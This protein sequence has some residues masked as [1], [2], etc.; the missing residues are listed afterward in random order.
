MALA[1]NLP[2][3][4]HLQNGKYTLGRVLGEGGFGITYLS[5]H[6]YLKRTVAIKELFPERAMRHGTTVS[7]PD[8]QKRDFHMEKERVLDEAR[9]ISRLDSPHIV[10]VDD[11]F[12]E[13]NTAYIVMEYLE[14]QSLQE[15]IEAEGPLPPDDVH[16]IAMAVCDALTEVHRQ[17]LLHRDIKPANIMLTRDGRVVLVDFGS[18]RAFARGQTIRHTR[19]LTRDYAAPEMYST[20]ARFGPYTDLFCLGATL[21]NALMGTPLASAMDRLQSVDQTVRFPSAAPDSLRQAV[22]GALNYRIEDRPQT[23]QEFR[24]LLSGIKAPP[25]RRT[26]SVTVDT[27]EHGGPDDGISTEVEVNL[28]SPSTTSPCIPS[29]QVSKR[30]SSVNTFAPLRK[31]PGVKFPVI[32]TLVPGAVIIVQSR[33]NSSD[34]LQLDSGAWIAASLVDD[35]PSR[36]PIATHIPVQ[37][38]VFKLPFRMSGTVIGIVAFGV[39]LVTSV[40]VMVSNQV[41]QTLPTPTPTS[42]P[43]TSIPTSTKS[44]PTSTPSP[45]PTVRP[46]STRTP[47]RLPTRIPTAQPSVNVHANLREGPGV[48]FPVIGTLASGA[49]VIVKSRTDSGDWIQLDSGAWIAAFLVDNVPSRLPIATHI[50][51]QPTTVLTSKFSV[52]GDA[53]VRSGPGI[54]YKIIGSRK[55]GDVLVP[56][57]KTVDREWLQLDQN[58]W[59][60]SGLVAGEIESLPF[61]YASERSQSSTS[62]ASQKPTRTPRPS[63][64]SIPT[65]NRK[66]TLVALGPSDRRK[67]FHCLSAWDGNHDGLER[68]VKRHLKDPNSMKT[69]ETLIAP[70]TEDSAGRLQHYIVMEFGATNSFG[71]MVRT[72]AVGWIDHDHCT[73]TLLYIE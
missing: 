4:T 59:I 42:I 31:G 3:G 66:A 34:W 58:S 8:S 23:V 15:R 72:K 50:P 28:Q 40:V 54:N 14:G 29:D 24:A 73:A 46:T 21:Y 67:G 26:A 9:V 2:A 44:R 45:R 36:L 27:V 57:A 1:R 43:V 62:N 68:L 16:R 69:Y 25:V 41:S 61:V 52:K 17:D 71:A 47:T 64:T 60:W 63:P 49:T 33:T 39:I 13:N 32:S 20:Q 30:Q 70:A 19:M 65:P 48:D 37:L 38:S 56:I 22:Q 6:R 18:A 51:G 10:E 11:A 55:S 7:V 5:A 12:L 53:N 35:V